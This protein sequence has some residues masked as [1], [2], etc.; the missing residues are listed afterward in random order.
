VNLIHITAFCSAEGWGGSEGESGKDYGYYM[1]RNEPKKRGEQKESG[2]VGGRKGKSRVDTTSPIFFCN[3]RVV[4]R[5]QKRRR[6][7]ARKVKVCMTLVTA[8]SESLS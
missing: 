5:E 7:T 3:V 4:C 1:K 6:T 2:R 8:D